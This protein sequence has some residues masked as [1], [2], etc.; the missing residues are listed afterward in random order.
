M[1]DLSDNVWFLVFSLPVVFQPD[2]AGGLRF[3]FV[4]FGLDQNRTDKSNGE[5]AVTK[6]IDL[7]H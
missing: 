5:T 1:Y 7:Q 3:G 4:W 6:E 2:K